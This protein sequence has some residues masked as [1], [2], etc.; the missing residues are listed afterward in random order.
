MNEVKRIHLS[1]Q[2]FTIAADAHKELR[3]YL[4]AI[5]VQTGDQSEVLKEVELRMAEL[6]TERGITAEKVVLGEDIDFLKEQLGEPKDFKED[7]DADGT[8]E[9]EEAEDGPKR[10]YRDTEHG[11]IAGVAAGIAAYLHIDALFVRL[12]FVLLTFASGAGILLYALIWLLAPEARTS[13]DKLQMHGKA[14]TVDSLKA[15]VDRADIPGAASRA[16]RTVQKILRGVGKVLLLILGIGLSVAAAGLFL[17]SMVASAYL[18]MNGA[19]VGDEIVFPVGSAAVTGLLSATLALFLLAFLLLIIGIAMIRRR[20]TLPGWLV[21]A[22]LGT[23]F[24]ALA[25]STATGF[26]VAPEIRQ[27]YQAMHQVNKVAV[28]AFTT[29]EVDGKLTSFSFEPSDTYAVEMAYFGKKQPDLSITTKVDNG[30][31]LV[32]TSHYKSARERCALVCMYGGDGLRVIIHAPSLETAEIKGQSNAFALTKSLQQKQLGLIVHRGNFAQF[33]NVTANKAIVDTSSADQGQVTLEDLTV[34]PMSEAFS[35]WGG[36]TGVHLEKATELV[37]QSGERT[38]W[39]GEPDF[40]IF[41]NEEPTQVH[42]NG[43]AY[44][45]LNDIRNLRTDHMG[46]RTDYNCFN[47]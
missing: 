9:A 36:P 28:P 34:S 2:S 32:D 35:F 10:L 8:G 4:H 37:L 26:K 30:K 21:A 16:S 18:L 47:F 12:A 25:V 45:T 33:F 6:L 3:D 39:G 44:A 11:M 43:K 24:V 20:W 15:V 22:L 5:E 31:L 38:C 17:A 13:S 19:Q 46:I 40:T 23:F 7:A 14:V 41:F 1:R 29:L 27:K 42:V